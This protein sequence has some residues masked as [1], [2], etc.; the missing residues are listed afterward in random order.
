MFDGREAA[1]IRAPASHVTVTVRLVYADAH[2]DPM[3]RKVLGL[4]GQA[5]AQSYSG[6]RSWVDEDLTATTKE[7]AEAVEQL[8]H[9]FLDELASGTASSVHTSRLPSSEQVGAEQDVEVLMEFVNE[10]SDLIDSLL[11][12]NGHRSHSLSLEE[13]LQRWQTSR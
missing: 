12:R 4:I 2:L 1:A 8:N 11:V 5:L 9:K 3:G 6:E 7:V 13:E 10:Q